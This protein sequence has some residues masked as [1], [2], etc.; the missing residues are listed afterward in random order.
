MLAV[1]T[2]GQHRLY[3]SITD[4]S[5]IVTRDQHTMY[6][7]NRHVWHIFINLNTSDSRTLYISLSESVVLPLLFDCHCQ[8]RHFLH[9]KINGIQL[10]L[11]SVM[12]YANFIIS[13]KNSTLQSLHM[14]VAY[15]LAK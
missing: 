12:N 15:T 6:R 9:N 10:K 2:I 11:K 4:Q 8:T 5:C 7:Y 3:E 13:R 1:H 14:S